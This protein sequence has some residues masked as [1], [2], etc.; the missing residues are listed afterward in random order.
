LIFASIEKIE[1]PSGRAVNTLL[2]MEDNGLFLDETAR[3]VGATPRNI[4]YWTRIHAL[5]VR[6]RG[7]RNLYPP[8]TIALL[9]AIARLAE[10]EIHTTRYIRWLVDLALERPIMDPVFRRFIRERSEIDRILDA[11]RL[12]EKAST[13]QSLSMREAADA[14]RDDDEIIL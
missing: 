13:E 9:G 4:K 5:P 12:S 8:L 11:T 14:R 7:R 10:L 2:D 3:R 1:L 6:R